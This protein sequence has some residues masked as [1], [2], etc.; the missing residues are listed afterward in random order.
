MSTSAG[1]VSARRPTRT[2]ARTTMASTAGAGPANSAVTATVEP[3]A[4]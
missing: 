1:P 3:K 4:T 2:T